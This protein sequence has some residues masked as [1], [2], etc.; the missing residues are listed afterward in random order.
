MQ[1]L[2]F[3]IRYV[4]LANIHNDARFSQRFEAAKTIDTDVFR[5]E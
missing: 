3:G 5:R 4:K 1:P 2:Q